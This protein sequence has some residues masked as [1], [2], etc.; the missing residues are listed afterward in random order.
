MYELYERHGI[1]F[2]YPESWEL[3]EESGENEISITVSPHDSL[4]WSLVL[5]VDHHD[6]QELLEAALDAF[7]SDIQDTDVDVYPAEV[8]SGSGETIGCDVEFISLDFVIGASLRA[9]RTA[10]LSGIVLYQGTDEELKQTRDVL[11][12]ISASLE[13]DDHERILE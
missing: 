2:R 12:A 7:R 10:H 8:D 4:F 9:F 11:E 3:T 1:R 6:P 13:S 5:R